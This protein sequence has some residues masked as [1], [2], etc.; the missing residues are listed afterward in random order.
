M[1][2]NHA[3]QFG[4]AGIRAVL[5]PLPNQ[6]NRDLVMRVTAGLC[7]HL[8]KCSPEAPKQG[9]CVAYDGR[10]H[11]LEFARA[12]AEVA[13]AQG[14][15][16]Y[17]FEDTVP[18]PL[19][20]FSVTEL[21][22][23]AGVMITASHNPPE[24]NGYKVFWHNGAQIIPPHDEGISKEIAALGPK[25]DFRTLAYAEFQKQRKIEF[26]GR[27]IET[28]YLS[29]IET[30]GHQPKTV[31]SI[32]IA[33][34]AMHGV[35]ERIARKAFSQR[36]YTNCHS[37]PEQA[38]PD[39]DFPTVAF[40]N[41]EEKGAMDLVLKL[42]SRT[43]A[44]IVLANDPDA[45]RLAVACK[46]R[47][48][49]YHQLSGNEVGALLCEYQLR[50]SRTPEKQSIFCSIVS[51][52]LTALIARHYGAYFE[53]TLTGFKWIMNRA[54][55]KQKEGFCLALG[56]E[57]ALGYAPS[58]EVAD[59]DGISSAILMTEMASFY[60]KTGQNLHD[61]LI[62]LWLRFG[63]HHSTALNIHLD[64]EMAEHI[65]SKLD[66]LRKEPPNLLGKLA[67]QRFC[68]Y[69]T[70]QIKD[71]DGRSSQ[72]TLPSSNVLAFHLEGGHRVMIRPSGTEPKLKIYLDITLPL[73]S[74][75]ALAEC[76]KQA[77]AITT[78]LGDSVRAIFT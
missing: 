54:L 21:G 73:A 66:A 38:L 63:F 72:S 37:V 57:E 41:P 10:K 16:V 46:D 15:K 51:S 7:K 55:A 47:S 69:K 42:A 22:A 13:C 24:Y 59:K 64:S 35:G 17:T 76:Q 29:Y 5:G 18:T 52:P 58:S 43:D 39:P 23:S 4:T 78:Q 11:S 9:L 20:A 60:L 71:R 3:I 19:L 65:Q 36:G 70:G 14:F 1:T 44:D 28:L 49:S 31:D 45:D 25:Q 8:L 56:F 27:Q 75:E 40:P 2:Q 33:Y 77:S 48:G 30:L 50:H 32:C 6:M 67:V 12:V 74:C 68:D 26:V 34:T 53:Q 62:E 61:V